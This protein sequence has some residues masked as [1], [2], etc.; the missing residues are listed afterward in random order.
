MNETKPLICIMI[1]NEEE[2]ILRTLYSFVCAG[3]LNF[4]VYDTGSEDNSLT[5]LSNFAKN[6]NINI[7]I[8]QQIYKGLFNY[9]IARN[10]CLQLA[11]EHFDNKWILFIDADWY[12]ENVSLLEKFC[13]LDLDKSV[14]S[15]K[16]TTCNY[17]FEQYRLF[18]KTGTY[19]YEGSVHEKVICDSC[20]SASNYIYFKYIPS[21]NNSTF[22]RLEQDIE[23]LKN[24]SD[25]RS[26]FYYGQTLQNLN[27]NNEAINIYK[28]RINIKSMESRDSNQEINETYVC[29]LRLSK[30]DSC[31]KLYYLHKAISLLPDRV[32]ALYYISEYYQKLNITFL[33]YIYIKK[34]CASVNNSYFMFDYDIFNKKRWLL[35]SDICN[36]L[37]KN[38]ECIQYCLEGIKS[39]YIHKL[40]NILKQ[41]SY[42]HKIKNKILNLILYSETDPCYRLMRDI[43]RVILRNKNILYFFYTYTNKETRIESDTIYIHGNDKDNS[44]LEKTLLTLYISRRF[45]Y[46]FVVRSNI[47]SIID[48]DML[49]L[50][51]REFDYSGPL[52]Y[53]NDLLNNNITFASGTCIIM[54]RKFVNILIDY[55]KNK[56]IDDINTLPD[57]VYIGL[58]AK[59]TKVKIFIPEETYLINNSFNILKE[60]NGYIVYRFKTID[61]Y[62]DVNDMKSFLNNISNLN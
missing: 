35:A 14:Y 54:S 5:K 21:S 34:C 36:T 12:I 33:C 56:F 61:R 44:I 42:I 25:S 51:L 38:K 30:L 18:S 40:A 60:F 31:K 50:Y 55:T 4:F 57:D 45:N 32:E 6:N 17:T 28:K 27:R 53:K 43:Q 49:D 8:E 48:F 16:I 46:N 58:V 13:N 23:R 26:L 19:N 20:G 15:V 41:N 11:R 37:S 24:C 3:Y 2:S 47:S 59:K 52:M 39:N 62:K 10:K 9:S 22:K 1:K 7:V 29:L